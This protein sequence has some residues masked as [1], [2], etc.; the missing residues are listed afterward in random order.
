MGRVMFV[1]FVM[2][3]LVMTAGLAA[4]GDFEMLDIGFSPTESKGVYEGQTLRIWVNVTNNGP[5]VNSSDIDYYMDSDLKGAGGTGSMNPGETRQLFYDYHTAKGDTGDRNFEAVLTIEDDNTD[6]NAAD[7]NYFIRK[8]SPDL[9]VEGIEFDRSL[10]VDNY[11]TM[12][13]T[14]GNKNGTENAN[15]VQVRISEDG[16]PI[17][18]GQ[19]SQVASGTT[20]T[21]EFTFLLDSTGTFDYSVESDYTDEISEMD[22]T[23]ND[24]EKSFDVT[25][26]TGSDKPDFDPEV[27]SWPSNYAQGQVIDISATIWNN[28]TYGYSNTTIPVILSIDGTEVDR[29]TASMPANY[30]DEVDLSWQITNDPGDYYLNVTVDPDSEADEF[31]EDNNVASLEITVEPPLPKDHPD[32]SVI[33]D[34][35]DFTVGGHAVNESGSV[36]EDTDVDIRVTIT[37]IGNMSAEDVPILILVDGEE[38]V[39]NTF[40]IK[41]QWD[42]PATKTVQTLWAAVRG[43]HTIGVRINNGS[44]VNETD[45]EGNLRTENNYAERDIRVVEGPLPDFYIDPASIMLTADDDPITEVEENTTVKLTFDIAN[46]GDITG[47]TTVTVFDSSVPEPQPVVGTIIDKFTR[48]MVADDNETLTVEWNITG[49]GVHYIRMIALNES[50]GDSDFSN[51][52]GQVQ[53]DVIGVPLPD[54][55]ISEILLNETAPL[56]NESVQITF[57]IKNNGTDEVTDDFLIEIS[58]I[59]DTETLL[60]TV[61]YFQNIPMNTTVTS[62][63]EWDLNYFGTG[64][65]KI[66]VNLDPHSSGEPGFGKVAEY[67][68]GNNDVLVNITVRAVLA[69]DVGLKPETVT[70]SSAWDRTEGLEVEDE[71][72]TFSVDYAI[73]SGQELTVTIRVHNL[74]NQAM[75]HLRV[76][77][78]LHSLEE[79]RPWVNKTTVIADGSAMDPVIQVDDTRDVT[80]TI[81]SVPTVSAIEIW[82]IK[83]SVETTG[84]SDADEKKVNLGNNYFQTDVYMIPDLADPAVNSMSI[85]P[86]DPTAFQPVAFTVEVAN[87][88]PRA[89][90]T[91]LKLI[92]DDSAVNINESAGPSDDKTKIHAYLEAGETRTIYFNYSFGSE[93]LFTLKA[94]IETASDQVDEEN[95]IVQ[96][97]QYVRALS[98][99]EFELVSID[100]PETS[101]S[102][103]PLTISVSIRNTGASSAN[104]VT[105]R[106]DDGIE[107]FSEKVFSIG[108][109]DTTIV[110]TI[111]KPT[112]PGIYFINVMINPGQTI[113]ESNYDNNEIEQSIEVTE[114]EPEEKKDSEDVPVFIIVAVVGASIAAGFGIFFLLRR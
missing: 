1:M 17:T 22:E 71:Q 80:F 114:A 54:L 67:N 20:Q 30:Y 37:N 106:F 15:N 102:G 84:Q 92:V 44:V 113:V 55:I 111:W 26:P 105:I 75:D 27:T 91:S 104:D 46:L 10:I 34:D 50:G 14:I 31:D 70:L 48:Q 5:D 11:V 94:R 109:S 87:L 56:R 43:N 76:N 19:I 107:T 25:N 110:D 33:V 9:M 98:G 90:S 101:E 7:D 12:T 2:L 99:V 88:G 52:D 6:N 49:T 74:G 83:A 86:L 58:I 63:F 3:G 29:V 16:S 60:G 85:S 103:K 59:G 65:Y 41:G 53:V 82:Q 40:D 64:V 68:E 62:G 51:N 4:A 23:N 89:A 42:P 69:P 8:A 28:G 21:I 95:D 66:R 93:K 81:E 32:F 61:E 39:N 45:E 72:P 73:I 77:F 108:S 24:F 79:V 36:I 78:S 96:F 35:I 13:A 18:T 57:S 97:D 112:S 38:I 47:N 100:L